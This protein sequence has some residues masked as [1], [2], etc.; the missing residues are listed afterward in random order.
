MVWAP[1]TLSVDV[2]PTTG[3]T[4]SMLETVEKLEGI[5]YLKILARE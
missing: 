3:D 2:L 5:H 4:S 1:L